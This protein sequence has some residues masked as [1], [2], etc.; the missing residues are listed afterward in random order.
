[1][2]SLC[3]SVL[4]LNSNGTDFHDFL[5]RCCERLQHTPSGGHSFLVHYAYVLA[6]L[7]GDEMMVQRFG[8]LVVGATD[9]IANTL[10]RHH[11][12][13][14]SSINFKTWHLMHNSALGVAQVHKLLLE[15]IDHANRAVGPGNLLAI[16]ASA[17]LGRL[18][19]EQGLL[20]ESRAQLY[21]TIQQVDD[22]VL[23]QPYKAHLTKR[24]IAVEESIAGAAGRRLRAAM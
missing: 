10:G 11:P 13:T 9:E 20:D 8:H 19:L 2:L 15:N 23:L 12:A 7:E 18:L 3:N 5:V 21:A 16:N 24:L 22:S 6:S 1:M 4:A 14:I 17:I